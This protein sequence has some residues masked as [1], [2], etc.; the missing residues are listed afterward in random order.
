M[1]GHKK[2][3]GCKRLRGY[4]LDLETGKVLAPS[5]KKV[6]AGESHLATRLLTL[7]TEGRLSATCVQELAHLAMLEPSNPELQLLAKSGNY[8]EIGGNIS[9]DISTNFL[10][11][12][13]ICAPYRIRVKCLDRTNSTIEDDMLLLLPHMLFSSLANNYVERFH[14]LFPGEG[15]ETFWE[16]TLRTRDDRLVDH[17]LKKGQWKK[18]LHPLVIHGD[19]VA[20]ES[21]D[22]L[23]TWSFGSLLAS[24]KPSTEAH[25][26]M[27]CFP[28]SSTCNET[29][30]KV[31]DY[32]HWSLECLAT[33]IRPTCDPY[34]KPLKEG[35]PLFEYAGQRLTHQNY[36]GAVFNVIG[37]M[38]FFANTLQLP[39]WASEWPCWACDTHRDHFKELKFES[40]NC[41]DA[42]LARREPV[43]DHP[44]FTL[45]GV[46]SRNVRHD[47]LH[48]LFVNGVLSHVM[49]SLLHYT[50][51]FDKPGGHQKV[52]PAKRLSILFT[53]VQK[54]YTEHKVECR[55][56]NL[57]LSM[58]CN[59]KQPHA[60]HPMLHGKGAE[61]KH[62][63]K[64]LLAVLRKMLGKGRHIHNNMLSC[65][66]SISDLVDL[67]DGCG[68][69]LSSSE[70]KRT[71]KLHKDFVQEY[72]LLGEWAAENDRYLFHIVAK[73]HM[74]WHMC[75]D[76]RHQNPRFSACWKGEDFVGKMSRLCHSCSFG[77]KCTRLTTKVLPKYQGMLHLLLMRQGRPL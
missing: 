34:G 45:P 9:R 6:K 63:V 53:E 47:M 12:L 33:G 55:L 42:S 57:T 31:W 5:P 32:L 4:K 20:Y 13:G 28:K 3:Q 69:F 62:L 60:T 77:T 37:D 24:D 19:G 30:P 41:V 64:P 51:W 16:Q 74:M 59:P 54:E 25:I 1:P 8:G 40:H 11:G 36:K 26:L 17:P 21:R 61:C 18:K 38:E 43:S 49:G 48:V 56:T 58:F 73:H 71:M 35:D 27:A 10:K 29:W 70:W 14:D 46:T 65:L 44:L 67:W 75:L 23:M 22:S 72:K 7:W 52:A 66:Q 15:L 76:S 39:H 50:C 2:D 68:M